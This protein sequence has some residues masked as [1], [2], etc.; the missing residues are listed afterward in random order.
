MSYPGLAVRKRRVVVHEGLSLGETWSRNPKQTQGIPMAAAIDSTLR[1]ARS[2]ARSGE[3][4]AAAELY[5]GVLARF[6][7][8]RR[9]QAGLSEATCITDPAEASRL[10]QEV[11]AFK[12]LLAQGQGPAA[13]VAAR[14]L[15]ARFPHLPELHNE[16]GTVCFAL[17]KGDEA[18]ACYGTAHRLNPQHPDFASNYGTLL[19]ARD[20]EGIAIPIFETILKRHPDHIGARRGLGRAYLG[21]GQCTLAIQAFDKLLAALPSD[22]DSYA[23]RATARFSLGDRDSAL[24]DMRNARLLVPDRV[25]F[26]R[27]YSH[28][29]RCDAD[30]PVIPA[31]EAALTAPAQHP[32]D[33]LRLHFSL[34]KIRHDL[35]ETDAAFHHWQAGNRIYKAESGYTLA[36]HTTLFDQVKTLARQKP[37]PLSAATVP[38]RRPIFVLGMPRSGTSLAEQI[39]TCH[40]A[41]HGAGELQDLPAAITGVGGLTQPLD[42]DALSSIRNHYLQALAQKTPDAPWVIDKMPLNFQF[43]GQIVT[44]IPEARIIHIRRDPMATCWSNYR[45]YFPGGGRGSDFSYDLLDLGRYWRLYDDLMTFWDE[46]YPGAVHSVQYEDLTGDLAGKAKGM[47]D[48]IGLAWEDSCLNF[49]ENKRAVMTTSSDQ[50]RRPLYQGSSADW[51]RYEHHLGPL[52]TALGDAVRDM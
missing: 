26:M 15:V 27:M 40:S 29:A 43:I 9:A 48:H 34:A 2:L 6:P 30:D 20:K 4:S 12:S 37:T 36:Y 13:L 11:T 5:L 24:D 52:R 38:R 17:S 46:T 42:R 19:A 8:N 31:M 18:E 3:K 28:M 45:N 41:I 49:H 25:E 22:A 10:N 50:V 32:Q 44:A 7:S 51:K 23:D 21:L 14:D 33:L 16:L 47:L 1:K 39:L 35:D